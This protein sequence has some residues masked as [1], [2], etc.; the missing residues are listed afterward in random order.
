M[1]ISNNHKSL[2]I[3]DPPPHTAN[4]VPELKSLQST[5]KL[6][7]RD[8]RSIRLILFYFLLLQFVATGTNAGKPFCQVAAS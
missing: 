4:R 3:S 1:S 8:R 2:N 5:K 6:P 7:V